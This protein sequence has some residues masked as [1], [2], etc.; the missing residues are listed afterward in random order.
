MLMSRRRCCSSS[1][2]AARDFRC[3]IAEAGSD[4]TA[5]LRHGLIPLLGRRAGDRLVPA[6]RPDLGGG[7]A[8]SRSTQPHLA[9]LFETAKGDRRLLRRLDRHAAGGGAR[10]PLR[11]RRGGSRLTGRRRTR[12]SAGVLEDLS[13]RLD[14]HFIVLLDRFEDLL[15]APS[16]EAAIVQFANELAEAINQPRLPANFLIALAEEAKP[17]LA[18]LRSRIPGFDD[19]SLKLAAATRL[20]SGGGADVAP[21]AGRSS[22]RRNP[23]RPD[24]TV[25]DRDPVPAPARRARIDEPSAPAKKKVKQPPLPRRNQDRGRLRDDRV[26]ALASHREP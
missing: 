17:R 25:P 8:L 18:G 20:H 24:R 1:S 13:Q 4:K 10:S 11:S 7:R 16:D 5:L 19:S 14:A 12:A 3:C 9:P 26:G 6:C 23:A 21:R 22:S 15:Q 2:C